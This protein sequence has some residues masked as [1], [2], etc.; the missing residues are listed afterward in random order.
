[1]TAAVGDRDLVLHVGDAA[2]SAAGG[3]SR[4]VRGHLARELDGFVAE[5]VAS[6]DPRGT[7]R[8]RRQRPALA[9]M[10]RVARRG[11]VRPGS[12][13]L[14]VH[15]SKGFSHVREGLICLL[16]RARGWRVVVTWHASSGLSAS[17]FSLGTLRIA[18]RSAHVVTVLSRAHAEVVPVPPDKVV[19]IPNDVPVPE[20][21]EEMSVREPLVVFAGEFGRRK[22]GDVLLGAWSR[23]PGELRESW[24]LHVHGRVAGELTAAAAAAGPSVRVH[25][26][27]PPAEVLEQLAR[28]SVAVLP[29]RAEALPGFLLEAMAAGCAVV[30]T[31]VGAVPALLREGAGVLVRPDD[32]TALAEALRTLLRSPAAREDAGRAAR[33]RVLAEHSAERVTRLWADLYRDVGHPVAD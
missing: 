6:F 19:V 14:H 12:A 17:R 5:A 8:L 24:T 16:G 28:A 7:S 22:G 20:A 18:L 30:G 11:P 13:I 29:S 21:T 15:V 1:M 3:I 4:V 25:G 26:L 23:L 10:R 9:A 2:D 31:E 32:E 27:T 33:A